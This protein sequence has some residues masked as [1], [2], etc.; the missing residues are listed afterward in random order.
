[1]ARDYE[2]LIT[3]HDTYQLVCTPKVQLGEHIGTTEGIQGS[4]GSGGVFFNVMLLSPRYSPNGWRPLS[5]FLKKKNPMAAGK[6]RVGWSLGKNPLQCTPPWLI[7]PQ[8]LENRAGHCVVPRL[9]GG[10]SAGHEADGEEV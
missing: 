7:V 1:M 3:L 6:E 9:A 10:Q 2:R 8:Q 4:V 5:F